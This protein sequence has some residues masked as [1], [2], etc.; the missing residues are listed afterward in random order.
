MERKEFD[1]LVDELVDQRGV[2]YPKLTAEE[3]KRLLQSY[4]H[5]ADP[6]GKQLAQWVLS[7]AHY[8]ECLT[9]RGM[10]ATHAECVVFWFRLYGLFDEV[11]DDLIKKANFGDTVIASG[12]APQSFQLDIETKVKP[13]LA[14]INKAFALFSEDDLLYLQFRRDVEAHVWQDAYRLRM[15]GQKSL[16]TTRRVFGV[17]WE[18]D[19]LHERIEQMLQRFARDERALAVDFA[20][21]LHPV[22]PEV[23]TTCMIYTS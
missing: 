11:R 18:L 16:I 23:L 21:R 13:A 2:G 9:V 3:N 22:M 19:V 12:Q 14:A 7:T 5:N 6:R 4:G 1:K 8:C 17:D 15:K 20:R 10:E